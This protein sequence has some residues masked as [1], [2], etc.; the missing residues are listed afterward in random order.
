M[1]LMPGFQCEPCPNGF[2]GNHAKGY[3]AQSMVNEY[4]NQVCQDV[5]ECSLGNTN[6]SICANTIGSFSCKCN[7]GFV[8]DGGL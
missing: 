6:C 1:N 5:D 3:Q 4:T 2:D 8:G 7:I